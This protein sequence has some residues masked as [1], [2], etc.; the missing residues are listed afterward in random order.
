MSSNN[1]EAST[2]SRLIA[3][4]S[5]I[6]SIAV[7]CGESGE[8]EDLQSAE[9]LCGE[10]VPSITWETFGKG[11]MTTHCQ[12]CH[13][14]EAPNRK[15]APPE[16]SFDDEADTLEQSIAILNATTSESPTMPPNGGP[17]EEDRQ[18]LVLWLTCF[19]E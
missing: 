15:G 2:T 8:E 10:E 7:G 3:T 18:R 12:G 5:A 6:A 9:E 14:S 17:S 13:A 19:T 11:F 1:P 16:V 4:V